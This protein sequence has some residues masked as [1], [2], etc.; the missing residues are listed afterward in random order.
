MAVCGAGRLEHADGA[1]AALRQH[2]EAADRDER[3]EEHPE[4]E[5]RERDGLGVERVRLGDRGRRL[6]LCPGFD[7]T[8]RH[9]RCVEQRHDLG[10]RLH[11]PRCDERELVEEALRVL[12]DADDPALGTTDGPGVTNLQVERRSHPARHGDLA[13]AHRVAPGDECKHGAAERSVRILGAELERV[14]RAGDRHRLVLDHLDAAE[15]M[16][17]VSDVA[18]HVRVQTRIGRGVPGRA[19]AEIRRL[20]RVRRDGRADDSGHDRHGDEGEDQELLTPLPAKEAPSPPDDGTPCGHSP[21]GR[22]GV[23]ERRQDRSATHR[24]SFGVQRQFALTSGASAR[25]VRPRP[26]V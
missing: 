24:C 12:D 16:L 25:R 18:R 17:E 6:H 8:R 10:R 19:E 5:G 26:R 3:D 13:R 9:T 21:V 7:R 4:H 22:A 20:R 15:A 23:A 14:D 1:E 11:L 2:G